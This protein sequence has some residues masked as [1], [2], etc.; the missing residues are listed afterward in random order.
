LAQNPFGT[1]ACAAGY[2]RSGKSILL[3]AILSAQELLAKAQYFLRIA[4]ECPDPLRAT[5]LRNY[6][7]HLL[8]L[9]LEP[10]KRGTRKNQ[11]EE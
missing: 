2:F 8:D 7:Q 6:A 10:T 5:A 9:A 11:K 1:F 3:E 4:S